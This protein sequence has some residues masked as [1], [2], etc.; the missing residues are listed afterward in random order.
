M[1]QFTDF[2]ESEILNFYLK[3]TAMAVGP[4]PHLALLTVLPTD[5]T[6]TITEVSGFGYARE[7]CPF[8]DVSVSSG[9]T[10]ITNSGVITFDVVTGAGYTVKAVAIFS[11]LTSGN[12]LFWGSVSQVTLNV[13]DQYVVAQGNVVITLQ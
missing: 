11:A 8:G 3:A 4:V 10:S 9:V 13:N 7:T 5:P 2:I 1:A 12:A 6:D